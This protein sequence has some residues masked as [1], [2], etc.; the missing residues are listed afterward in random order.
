MQ[1]ISVITPLY[2]GQQYVERLMELVAH[3]VSCLQ[4]H[5]MDCS[6][7]FILVNDS[8]DS[9]VLLPEPRQNFTC[10]LINHEKNQGIHGARV[11]G[12]RH[13]GGEFILFLD[14]DDEI[15]DDFLYQQLSKIHSADMIVAN[16]LMEQPDGSRTLLYPNAYSYRK[17]TNLQAYTKSHNQIVSPGQCLIRRDAI[18][19]EWLSFITGRNGSDDL[20]LWILMLSKECCIVINDQPLYT[21]RYT[22]ANLSAD[23]D[24]MDDSSLEILEYLAQVPYVSAKTISDIRRSRTFGRTWRRSSAVGKLGMIVKNLDQLIPRAWWKLRSSL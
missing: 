20:F 17:I 14:Q 24:K 4:E 8:P 7:E 11:T 19:R 13:A 3:N 16:A 18:P 6:V 10:T 12:L 9:E 23:E 22:G 2:H 15:A 21:H 1:S 5:G